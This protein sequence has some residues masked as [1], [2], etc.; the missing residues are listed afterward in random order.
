M[1]IRNTLLFQLP[2]FELEEIEPMLTRVWLPAD[3]Q[4]LGVEHR[5]DYAYFPE[6]VIISVITHG[7]NHRHCYTGLYGFEG[8]GSLTTLLGVPTSPHDEVVQ[9]GGYAY[10][11]RAT[12]LHDLVIT[13]PEFRR[14]LNCYAHIFM[15]QIS[16]T[17]FANGSTR[18]D[19]RLARW[20]LMY[21]DR[22][23]ASSIAITHQRLSDM[24]GVR[25]SGITEALHLL[26]GNGLV[27]AQRGLIDILDRPRLRLLTA[28]SYGR[29]EAEYQ[30]LI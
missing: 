4:L 19:Q 30:R 6:S 12:D 9:L 5:A 7:D 29:P 17:A 15:M 1:S 11:I 21:Q 3:A 14:R 26:E 2:A 8:F 24:L 22:L 25:R 28:G 20:L 13:L 27:R 16:Y 23:H 10:Q 18:V